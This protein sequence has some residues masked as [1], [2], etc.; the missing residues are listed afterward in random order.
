[1]KIVE[2][3]PK[4]D[5]S[6]EAK[7]GT[8]DVRVIDSDDMRRREGM[9]QVLEQFAKMVRSG[10]ASSVVVCGVLEPGAD[11]DKS[12]E[13]CVGT[14]FYRSPQGSFFTTLGAVE[15]VKDELLEYHTRGN[16]TYRDI[17]DDPYD[18]DYDPDGIA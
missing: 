9:A 13:E 6:E 4:G 17:D 18:D 10:E 1:M 14:K 8:A 11:G 5:S 2:F 12:G 16:S 3:P 15:A 7:G